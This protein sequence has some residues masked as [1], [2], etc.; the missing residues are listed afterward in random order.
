MQ[1]IFSHSFKV[2][3]SG[4]KGQRHPK[5]LKLAIFFKTVNFLYRHMHLKVVGTDARNIFTQFPG[6][7]VKGHQYKEVLN[8]QFSFVI[9]IN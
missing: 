5:L 4:V 1:G 6:H 3:G 8:D 2:M 9:A 7:W